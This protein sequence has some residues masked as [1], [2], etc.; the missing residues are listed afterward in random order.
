ME[1]NKISYVKTDD[2]II[3][4]ENCI[5]WAKK[6]DECLL[7][8]IKTTGCMSKLETHQICKLNNLKS[9]E[10]LNRFF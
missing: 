7:V 1:N 3:L 10:K 6:M 5:R 9:Y 2:N 4:N 8:C